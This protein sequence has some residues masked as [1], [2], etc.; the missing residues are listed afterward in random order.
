MGLTFHRNRIL[1]SAAR[2]G[3]LAPVPAALLSVTGK[4]EAR[5][6]HRRAE[7]SS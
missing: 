3:A 1:A 4:S 2:G 7:C 5:A 6:Q